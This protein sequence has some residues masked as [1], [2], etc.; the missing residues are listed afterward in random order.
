MLSSQLSRRKSLCPMMLKIPLQWTEWLQVTGQFCLASFYNVWPSET[1]FKPFFS[2]QLVMTIWAADSLS[3][4]SEA[5]QLW[6][7]LVLNYACWWVC[8]EKLKYVKI[9]RVHGEKRGMALWYFMVVHLLFSC[10]FFSP[11]RL[12][13][14]EPCILSRQSKIW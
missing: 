4:K 12:K 11:Q 9:I 5:V 1:N 10:V 2:I 14:I 7:K 3:H 8:S 6:W 13:W